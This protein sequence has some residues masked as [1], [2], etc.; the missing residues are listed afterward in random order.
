VIAINRYPVDTMNMIQTT[1]DGNADITMASVVNGRMME[2]IPCLCRIFT[3]WM[4]RW[5]LVMPMI[6]LGFRLK[7]LMNLDFHLLDMEAYRVRP[8]SPVILMKTLPVL[9]WRV[10]ISEAVSRC[11]TLWI[12]LRQDVVRGMDH[13]FFLAGSRSFHIQRVIL[14]QTG[15]FLIDQY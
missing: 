9:L 4:I 7:A 2:T 14:Y 1:D 8:L 6:A 15:I 11:F 13:S 3:V 12:L 10:I 5:D